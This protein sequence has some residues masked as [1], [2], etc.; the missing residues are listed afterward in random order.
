MEQFGVSG[1]GSGTAGTGAGNPSG[2][3]GGLLIVRCKEIL[4]LGKFESLGTAGGSSTNA[5]RRSF[6][7]WVYKFIFRK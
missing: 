1:L 2:G 3:T 5:R 4:G 6:W 7:W